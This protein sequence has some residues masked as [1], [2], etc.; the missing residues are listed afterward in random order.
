M[1]FLPLTLTVAFFILGKQRS[2]DETAFQNG[3]LMGMLLIGS[4]WAWTAYFF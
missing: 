4:I 3:S 2:T 1:I